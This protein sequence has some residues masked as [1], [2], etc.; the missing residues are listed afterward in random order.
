[1]TKNGPNK[2]VLITGTS[3]GFG[4]T[5]ARL[6]ASNGWNVVATMRRPEAEKEFAGLDKLLVTRLGVQDQASIAGQSKPALRV[7]GGLTR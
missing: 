2:T 5:T 7:S 1:M 4:R 3:S 6:F